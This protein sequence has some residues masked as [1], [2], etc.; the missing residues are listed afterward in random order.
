MTR[1]STD[2]N[3]TCNAKTT[4]IANDCIAT[5]HYVRCRHTESETKEKKMKMKA[6]KNLNRIPIDYSDN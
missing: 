5:I 1:A 4:V 6:D 2:A 3:T